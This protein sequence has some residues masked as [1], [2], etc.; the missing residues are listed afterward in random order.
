MICPVYHSSFFSV[1]PV[2]PVAEDTGTV[3]HLRHCAKYFRIY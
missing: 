3:A 1:S 2:L